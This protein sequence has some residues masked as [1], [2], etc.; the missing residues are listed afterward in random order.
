[1]VL[2]HL[3]SRAC[4]C[5]CVWNRQCG[6]SNLWCPLLLTSDDGRLDDISIFGPVSR[7][8]EKWSCR[9]KSPIGTWIDAAVSVV[10][11]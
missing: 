4:V 7:H 2:E 11:I 3:G 10:A 5:V 6:F 1:M 9:G 8:R